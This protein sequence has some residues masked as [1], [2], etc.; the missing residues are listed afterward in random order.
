MKIAPGREFE[1]GEDKIIDDDRTFFCSELV[2]DAF[3]VL[4][5]IENDDTACSS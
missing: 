2:A 3:K 5:I 1:G 4:N